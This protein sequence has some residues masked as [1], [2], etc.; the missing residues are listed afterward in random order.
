MIEQALFIKKTKSFLARCPR[1]RIAYLYG[2]CLTRKDFRDIDLAL[3]LADENRARFDSIEFR[4]KISTALHEAARPSKELDVHLLHEMPLSLQY[5]VI[6]SGKCIFQRT[7]KER[8]DYETRVLN[9]F[10]DFK[11][12]HDW[13]VQQTLERA[14]QNR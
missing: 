13:L 12:A 2:S 10:L 5:R 4:V 9:Q 7:G 8:V 6:S 3:G 11:P 14:S 1:I